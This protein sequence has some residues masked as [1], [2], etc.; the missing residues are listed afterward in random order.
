MGY[1]SCSL[2]YH[3]QHTHGIAEAHRH[4]ASSKNRENASKSRNR[5]RAQNGKKVKKKIETIEDTEP[6]EKYLW[7]VTIVIFGICFFSML[8]KY[9]NYFIFRSFS[10]LF[11]VRCGCALF[12]LSSYRFLVG[13][14]GCSV[15][16][17]KLYSSYIL[18]F[19]YYSARIYEMVNGG[20]ERVNL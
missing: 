17:Q 2:T 3:I 9:E 13:C 7:W 15:D 19:C 18:R 1:S 11:V 6:S 8:Q 16:C 4:I 5:E 12:S 20:S 10:L 14:T